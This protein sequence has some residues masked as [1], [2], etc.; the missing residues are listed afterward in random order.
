MPFESNTKTATLSGHC[1]VEE[2]EPLMEWLLSHR[3]G[4][5]DLSGCEH[6]HSAVLQVLMALRPKIWKYPVSP[7]LAAALRG[8]KIED[9]IPEQQA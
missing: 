3:S 2:A 7:R 9:N 5:L 8:A 1:T 4:R 6:V